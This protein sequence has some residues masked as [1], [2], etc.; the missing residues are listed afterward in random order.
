MQEL[1]LSGKDF[2][3]KSAVLEL[4]D[5]NLISDSDLFCENS[6][7]P[8]NVLRNRI[9]K[10]NLI[11]YKCAICGT[12]EWLGRNLSLELDHINGINNDNRL[13]NL[14]FLC[15][16]CHSQTIT[17]GSKN[18]KITETEYDISED[19]KDQIISKYLE[20]K[21]QKRVSEELNIKPKIIKEIITN[22]GLGKSNQK[23]V[24][25]YDSNKNEINRFGTISE[26]CEYLMDNELVK[27]KILK[28]C[29]NTLLRNID[30]LWNN[31]YFKLIET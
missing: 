20:L 29:R 28:T 7:H 23:Y 25:Q 19:L 18:Q 31:Y 16:N 5:Q 22:A 10:N 12:T 4:N 21:N 6:K 11:P 26:C 9:I 30:K 14:R 17:Y 1:D 13:E 3:R 24:I 27:T 15:P 2:R 8:R